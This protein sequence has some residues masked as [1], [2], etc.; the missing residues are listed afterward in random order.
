MLNN[1]CLYMIRVYFTS[2]FPLAPLKQ[3]IS[4]ISVVLLCLKD[5][6][7]NNSLLLTRALYMG[8]LI[9]LSFNFSIEVSLQGEVRRTR[10]PSG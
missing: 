10:D 6:E 3:K 8:R 7:P 2:L 4:V 1:Y 9:E 5:I